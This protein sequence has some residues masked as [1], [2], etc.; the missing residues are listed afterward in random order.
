MALLPN[1]RSS[2]WS[3]FYE[4]ASGATS[5]SAISYTMPTESPAN[6]PVAN[7]T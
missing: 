5:L 2:V 7:A 1:E 3:S 4:M 6:R